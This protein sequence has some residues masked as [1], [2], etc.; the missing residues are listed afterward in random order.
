MSSTIKVK[1]DDSLTDTFDYYSSGT[2][3][4]KSAVSFTSD[5]ELQFITL[6]YITMTPDEFNFLA[7]SIELEITFGGD[8]WIGLS[9]DLELKL[10]AKTIEGLHEEFRLNMEYLIDHIREKAD[11]ELTDRMQL[12][13]SNLKK[14]IK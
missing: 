10:F 14:Y 6:S 2:T 11:S 13:K 9:R 3:L 7:K 12:V 8:V 5:K 1:K 4:V